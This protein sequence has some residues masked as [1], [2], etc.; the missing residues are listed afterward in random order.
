MIKLKLPFVKV[1]SVIILTSENQWVEMN[2]LHAECS[3]AD[4]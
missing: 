2:R 1:I 4:A 3:I